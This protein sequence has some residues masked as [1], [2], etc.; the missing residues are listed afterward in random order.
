MATNGSAS[1]RDLPIVSPSLVKW[2]PVFIEQFDLGIREE[3]LPRVGL[4]DETSDELTDLTSDV[5]EWL[6]S[7]SD[8]GSVMECD[9]GES[10]SMW[11]SDIKSNN[12][13]GNVNVKPTKRLK[14][15]LSNSRTKVKTSESKPATAHLKDCTN[16]LNNSRFVAPVSSPEREKAAKGV[17]PVN[18]RANSNWAI[19]NFKEWAS[20][21]LAMTPDD[22]VPA[23]LLQSQDPDLLCKW[24]CRYVME[25]RR[26][27]GS[28][29]PPATLR[30]LL[31]G[32][33]RVIQENKAP[34]SILDK[35][36]YR[37]KDLLNTLDTLCS[38]LHRQGMGA[39]KNVC[40]K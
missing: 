30:S 11:S 29:Y 40:I 19:K 38:N 33:N 21:R 22:P 27:D 16:N 5:T 18:T 32:V 26:T 6:S 12:E 39:T 25:T 23:D 7:L 4:A 10:T 20:N 28:L 3:W 24:L 34:F 9:V 2:K 8:V 13:S 35:D 15:S 37:F 17:I 14:L 1:G 36:D 31:S